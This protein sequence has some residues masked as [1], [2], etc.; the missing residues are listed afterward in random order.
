MVRLLI[1]S[2]HAGDTP[3]PIDVDNKDHRGLTPLN[4]AA[5][6]GDLDLMKVLIE[7]GKANIEEQSP[8][9]CTA[10]MYAS[11]GGNSNM[12]KYL[13]EKGVNSLK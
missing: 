12:V 10:L 4:C 2:S 3:E 7:K 8:K 1:E 5:I 6:K 13:L 11:R 9:G